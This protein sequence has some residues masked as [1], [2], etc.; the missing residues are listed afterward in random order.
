MRIQNN[1]EINPLTHMKS[2]HIHEGQKFPCTQCESIFTW[3]RHLLRHMKS[4]HEGQKFP[5]TQCESIF[6]R[7]GN[8]QKHI[9]SVHEC[10][11]DNEENVSTEIEYFE[12]DIKEEEKEE[13]Y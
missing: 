11:T 1:K 13:F 8:L 6:T 5:C 7:K 2:V 3:K 12:K 9:K 10:R 4:V